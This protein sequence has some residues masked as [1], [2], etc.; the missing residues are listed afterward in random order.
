MMRLNNIVTVKHR[1]FDP[2]SHAVE[3]ELVR[4]AGGNEQARTDAKRNHFFAKSS[5]P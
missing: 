1:P 3:G 4:D 5:F 2:D